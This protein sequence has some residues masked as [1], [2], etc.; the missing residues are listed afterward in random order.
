LQGFTNVEIEERL[1]IAERTVRRKINR[2][3]REWIET[4]D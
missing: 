1:G 4:S 3:R 2:I